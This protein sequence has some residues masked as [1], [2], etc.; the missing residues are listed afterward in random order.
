MSLYCWKAIGSPIIT[1]SPT[2]LK[3]FDGRGFQPYGILPTLSIDSGG[4]TISMY[5]EVVDAPL[6]YLLDRN[7]FY[8]MAIITS[9]IFRLIK[10]PHQG[11]IITIDQLDFCNL[12]VQTNQIKQFLSWDILVLSMNIQE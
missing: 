1:S 4:K 8:E 10:F 6:Y 9:S 3:A 2:T 11:K 5:V 7:W 12:N